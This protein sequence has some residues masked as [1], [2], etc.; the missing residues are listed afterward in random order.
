MDTDEAK[1]ELIVSSVFICVHHL[2]LW[3][4]SLLLFVPFAPSWFNRFAVFRPGGE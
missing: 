2:H 1:G 3:P 4:I